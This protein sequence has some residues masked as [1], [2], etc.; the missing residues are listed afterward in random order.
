MSSLHFLL[1]RQSFQQQLLRRPEG[2][3]AIM[4][5]Q[6]GGLPGV[7]GG[8]N[9][10]SSPGSIQHMPQQQPR[11]FFDFAQQQGSSQEGQNR[12]QGMDQQVLN[13]V[14]QAYLQYAMQAHQKSAS[15][16]QPQQQHKMGMLG[17]SSNK[18]QDIRMG[19]M[20][21]MQSAN[22]AQPSSSKMSSEQFPR[23]EKPMEQ[24]QLSVSDQRNE[25]KPQSQQVV[26]GQLLSGNIIR[27]MQ[28]PQA[29][30]NVQNVAN[31]QFAMAAQLQAWALERNIDLSQPANAHIM[32]Q[33]I[34]LMQS[35]MAAHQKANESSMSGQSSP[36]QQVTSAS[37]ATENSPHA[38]SSA[39]QSTPSGSAK[40][41]QMV[42][43]SPLSATSNANNVASQHF[44]VHGRENQVPQRQL[45]SLA[46]GM[47]PM[48]PPQ[49]SMSM[50][51]GAEKPLPV[52]NASGPETS[53]M[54]YLRQMNR[55]SPQAA[56]PSSEGGLVK[57]VSSQSGQVSQ[58]PQQRFGFTK[59]QLHVLKAQ[60]LAFRRI[61]VC[62][63]LDYL[64][65]HVLCV[66][67]VHLCCMH[68]QFKFCY[69]SLVLT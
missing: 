61:K 58:M 1:L 53:Q 49:S 57:K 30:Q 45:G 16:M 55:S 13:P 21:P 62:R 38:N 12:S 25:L 65:L 11:K 36:R 66:S 4:A 32:A 3:E 42:S 35:K 27:P 31:N 29:Q 26:G 20:I 50:S 2:N 48:H 34:P 44:S 15:A 46:N 28:A 10:G 56:V 51:Q 37:V 6:M 52:K 40:S 19:N 54:Q 60:I 59:Q 43:P 64:F 63:I 17:P 14:H 41:R 39:D 9:F 5:Y 24:G 23:S 33:L 8:G 69:T 47:A 67:I 22:Q 7:M 68:T 18:G